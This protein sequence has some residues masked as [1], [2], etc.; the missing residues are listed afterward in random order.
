MYETPIPMMCRSIGVLHA[1]RRLR[2]LQQHRDE[3]HCDEEEP[4]CRLGMS[5]NAHSRAAN[6]IVSRLDHNP[7]MD[8]EAQDVG[9]EP[10]RLQNWVARAELLDLLGVVGAPLGADHAL[11][12]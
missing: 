5:H 6:S 11:A 2:T 7:V 4:G 9:G 10:L 8:E 12:V 1:L 3:R